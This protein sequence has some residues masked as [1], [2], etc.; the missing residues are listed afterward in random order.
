MKRFAIPAMLSF[1]L[2]TQIAQ[3][4]E[5]IVGDWHFPNESCDMAIHLGALSMKSE[6]VNCKFT[7]VKR[8]GNR[9]TWKGVCDDAE[10]SSA[11]TVVATLKA[12]RLTI[13]YMKGGN[14]L[15]DLQRCGQ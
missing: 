5:S 3:S 9:V 4:A 15:H 2:N 10:G 8:A 11:E 7:S 6:D 12:G 14:V 1:L 13:R